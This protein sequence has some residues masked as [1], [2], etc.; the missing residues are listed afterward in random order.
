[1][2]AM[3]SLALL[4]SVLT[5]DRAVASPDTATLTLVLNC[6]P[7]PRLIPKVNYTTFTHEFYVTVT[8]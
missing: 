5:D 3:I 7:P 4:N 2:L 6:V 1:V 8:L